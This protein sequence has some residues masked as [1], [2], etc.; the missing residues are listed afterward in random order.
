MYMYMN[1][2]AH[3]YTGT[4]NN[5]ARLSMVL[6]KSKYQRCHA[7]PQRA[8]VRSSY[9][10]DISMFMYVYACTHMQDDESSLNGAG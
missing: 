5:N 1:M 2:Y 9:I 4:I 8:S 7:L 6:A 10:H 3:I